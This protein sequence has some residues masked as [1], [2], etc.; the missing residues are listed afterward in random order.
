MTTNPAEVTLTSRSAARVQRVLSAISIA[1][2]LAGGV[3]IALSGLRWWAIMLWELGLLLV[4]FV[5]AALWSSVSS[6]EQKTAALRAKGIAAV[7]QV[8]DSTRED[9]GETV[10]HVLTL[11]IPSGGGFEVHHRCGHHD[12]ERHL[13]VLVDPE[14]HTWAVVH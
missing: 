12:G 9:D 8:L 2:V 5:L 10:T 4:L 3:A 13:E 11:W 1:A 14:T 6:E 7:A